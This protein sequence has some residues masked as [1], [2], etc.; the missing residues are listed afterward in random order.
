MAT[1]NQI[2]S[3]CSLCLFLLSHSHL[4][5]FAGEVLS[6]SHVGAHEQL[7]HMLLLPPILSFLHYSNTCV[8]FFL[9]HAQEP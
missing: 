9:R 5:V 4:C 1:S 6:S 2:F 3:F 8:A 7:T